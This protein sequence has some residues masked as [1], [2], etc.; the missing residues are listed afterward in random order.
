VDFQWGGDIVVR[1][2][3]GEALFTRAHEPVLCV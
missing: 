3:G 2:N 1:D